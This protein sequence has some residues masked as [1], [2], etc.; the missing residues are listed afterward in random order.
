MRFI[1]IFCLLAVSAI[2]FLPA[3]GT[4]GADLVPDTGGPKLSVASLNLARQSASVVAG[5]LARRSLADADILL[6]QEVVH[7]DGEAEELEDVLAR[8]LG[9]HAAFAREFQLAP[10]LTEG[11]A[12]LSRYPIRDIEVLPLAEYDCIFNSRHRIALAVTADTPVGPVRVYNVHLDNRLNAGDRVRQVKTAVESAARYSGSALIGGDFNTNHIYWI[13]RL[14]PL[15]YVQKQATAV[16]KLMRSY[17]F[18]TPFMRTGSTFDHLGF[19]LDWLYV[20][21]LKPVQAGIEPIDFSDHHGIW[22]RL[23]L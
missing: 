10:G 1:G 2:P 18:R 23:E 15:P 19:Q 5:E 3:E 22:A 12:I 21:R 13:G 7:R 8:R 20:N 4:G 17:G 11:L 14:A 9:R 6:L 16:E